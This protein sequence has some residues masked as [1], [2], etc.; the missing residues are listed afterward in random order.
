MNLAPDQT[1]SAI[2]LKIEHLYRVCCRAMVATEEWGGD[3]WIWNLYDFHT[4]KIA[5][6]ET[7]REKPKD[8][9]SAYFIARKYVA[10]MI[11][12]GV[13]FAANIDQPKESLE[14]VKAFLETDKDY[15]HINN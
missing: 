15:Q 9:L 14:L 12:Q 7:W 1:G 6:F 3:A 8:H 2:P 11:Q 10:K 5:T 4:G 13:P